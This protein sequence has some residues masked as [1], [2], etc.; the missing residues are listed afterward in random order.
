MYDWEKAH[1]ALNVWWRLR[2][3]QEAVQKALDIELQNYNAT[4][5]QIDIL[6][7][8]SVS[9]VPLTPTQVASY[10]FREKHSTSGLLT[11][12]ERSGYVKKTR[13]ETDR[14]VMQIQMQPKGQV[15]L[16]QI[17]ESGFRY[18]YRIVK[19]SLSNEEMQQLDR[20]LKKLRDAALDEMGLTKQPYP[21]DT[22]ILPADFRSM[23]RRQRA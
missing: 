2:Q 9:R 15:L 7:I 20:L 22:L 1:P 16:K 12:M 19:S 10:T 8:L 18:A 4:L 5:S 13:S 11:R 14:R 21:L 17:I 6:M 3:T 23:V